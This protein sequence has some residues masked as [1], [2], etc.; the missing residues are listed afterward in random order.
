MRRVG[1]VVG[2]NITQNTYLEVVEKVADAD[3]AACL[4]LVRQL[5][6]GRQE[7]QRIARRKQRQQI[8]RQVL[9]HYSVVVVVV[10]SGGDFSV[11]VA[12]CCGRWSG[13]TRALCT[14]PGAA[15]M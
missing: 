6:G 9:R 12:A 14:R 7:G 15:Q 13:F 11:C 5:V 1:G 10:W 8:G 2:V 4:L 3:V